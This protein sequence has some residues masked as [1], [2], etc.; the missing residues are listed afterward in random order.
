MVVVLQVIAAAL[1][2]M[3]NIDGALVG[4][5]SLKM[6]FENIVKAKPAL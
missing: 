1:F 2:E 3:P 6:D 5:A 4:G